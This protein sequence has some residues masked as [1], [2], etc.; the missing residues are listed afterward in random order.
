LIVEEYFSDPKK[1]VD[2]AKWKT[3][4]YFVIK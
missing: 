1:E 3:N 2:P 4:I